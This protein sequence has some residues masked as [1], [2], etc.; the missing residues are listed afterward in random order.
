MTIASAVL[1]TPAPTRPAERAPVSESDYDSEGG[2]FGEQLEGFTQAKAAGDHTATPATGAN[3]ASRAVKSGGKQS[4]PKNASAPTSTAGTVSTLV[5][6]PITIA[7]QSAAAAVREPGDDSTDETE[8]TP[9]GES[10][11]VAAAPGTDSQAGTDDAPAANAEKPAVP[12]T[13]AGEAPVAS[14]QAAAQEMAFAARVQPAAQIS[15]QT[16][17]AFK[18][19]PQT[20][21]S[22]ALTAAQQKDDGQSAPPASG[23]AIASQ[24]AAAFENNR[25]LSTAP[26]PQLETAAP[27]RHTVPEAAVAEAKSGPVAPLRDVSLEVSTAGEDKVQVRVVQ[28]SGEL[29]IA[30]RTGDAAL[31]Q[32]LQQGLG[33]LASRL[34]DHG[35]KTETWRPASAPAAAAAAAGEAQSTSNRSNSGD[36][37]Q[38]SNWSRNQGG[39]QNH[40]QNQNQNQSNRPRWVEELESSLSGPAAFSGES[41][42]ISR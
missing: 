16:V 19:S 12:Q 33:D 25:Q 32:G 31:A 37:Q 35:Y 36:S 7:I 10:T 2:S 38:P 14:G 15:A 29:H 6:A 4:V 5:P 34:Q 42:G 40:N 13:Q 11:A 20:G 26:E 28:Q 1:S 30:V 41:Y 24:A 18:T 39:Q 17:G 22:A 3:R 21:G 27:V 8:A 23:N 9:G